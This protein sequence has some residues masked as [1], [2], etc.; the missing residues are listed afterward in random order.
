[1]ALLLAG[2]L[3]HQPDEGR[4]DHHGAAAADGG[5][6]AGG[7]HGRLLRGRAVGPPRHH[8]RTSGRT[9]R[10]RRWARPT[11]SSRSTPTPAAP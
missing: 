9:T 10:R 7:Q 3:R 1:V 11:T 6:H 5:Q 8:G 2:D 4:Q